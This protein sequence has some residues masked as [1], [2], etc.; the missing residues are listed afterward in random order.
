MLTAGIGQHS[1]SGQQ[2]YVQDI[3]SAVSSPWESLVL[4]FL[5]LNPKTVFA[6]GAQRHGA[7]HNSNDLRARPI[8]MIG[9]SKQ[10]LGAEPLEQDAEP[11]N[12]NLISTP[13]QLF[14]TMADATAPP[15]VVFYH[16]KRCRK[17]NLVMPLV[18]RLMKGDDS[19]RQYFDVLVDSREMRDFAASEGITSLPRLLVYTTGIDGER[20]RCEVDF[21]SRGS[22]TTRGFRAIRDAVHQCACTTAAEMP[23][24]ETSPTGEVAGDFIW[25]AVLPVSLFVVM[26]A[27]LETI[28]ADIGLLVRAAEPVYAEAA[29]A[30]AEGVDA[31]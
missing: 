17:C 27:R 19:S 2:A 16:K 8:R 7:S 14:A 9:E 12:F 28:L 13:D 5:A 1:R 21:E 15:S 25:S 30:I 31:L 29:N 3:S 23:W 22:G 24:A 11:K 20:R 10:N 18:R 6:S 26:G 4:L